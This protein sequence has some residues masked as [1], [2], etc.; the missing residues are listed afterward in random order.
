MVIK[1][2]QCFSNILSNPEAFNIIFQMRCTLNNV[3]YDLQSGTLLTNIRQ[4]EAL[5][6]E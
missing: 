3:Y 1:N 6:L 4:E 2:F 5:T